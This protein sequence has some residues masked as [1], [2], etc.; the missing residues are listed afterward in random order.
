M[1]EMILHWIAVHGYGVIFALFALGILGIPFP[2]EWLLAYLGYLIY[3]G[4]LL[5]V[6]TVASA[7]FG[8]ICGMTLN[9]LL[10]RTVGLYLVRKFGSILHLTPEKMSKMHDWYEHAGRWALLFGYFLPGVRH[11]TAVVAGTSK[12]TFWEFAL[13][14]YTG[15]FLWSNTFIALGYFLEEQWAK[16]TERIHHILEIGSVLALVVLALYLL[17]QKRKQK[18]G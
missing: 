18:S 16:E 5:P 14:A 2:D 15:G 3:K 6:P 12:M 8:S 13:F 11:M 10:G 7:F 4:R 9:Y 1:I 17:L